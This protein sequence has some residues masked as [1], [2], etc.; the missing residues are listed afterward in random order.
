MYRIPLFGGAPR[1]RG[2]C[3]WR[4]RLRMIGNFLSDRHGTAMNSWRQRDRRD[5]AEVDA[6]HVGVGAVVIGGLDVPHALALAMREGDL[7]G[8]AVGQDVAAQNVGPPAI[9]VR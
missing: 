7:R 5:G 1:H 3:R 9:L 4:N 8:L 6:P 2:F